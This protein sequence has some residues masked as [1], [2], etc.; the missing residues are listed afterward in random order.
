MSVF[1]LLTAAKKA[2]YQGPIAHSVWASWERKDPRE[3]TLLIDKSFSFSVQGNGNWKKE[4]R[5]AASQL[6]QGWLWLAQTEAP[7]HVAW[8]GNLLAPA[9]SVCATSH[10]WAWALHGSGGLHIQAVFAI[11]WS[12]LQQVAYPEEILVF[13]SLCGDRMHCFD[14]DTA[15]HY[16]VFDL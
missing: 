1:R 11:S 6:W 8:Y 2:D 13:L 3:I 9:T 5:D 4:S 10:Y 7:P 16:F 14:I 15:V 12:K